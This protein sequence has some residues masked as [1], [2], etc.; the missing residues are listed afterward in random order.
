MLSA[1]RMCL[2][3]CNKFKDGRMTLNDDPEEHR[4]WPRASH[5]DENCVIFESL[6]RE[7]RRVNAREIGEV[8]GIV[9]SALHETI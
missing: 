9:K 7:D 5:S 2:C 3:G 6:I 1:E 4:G 8:K